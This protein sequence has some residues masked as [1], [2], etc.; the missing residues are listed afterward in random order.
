MIAGKYLIEELL[1]KLG[2][3]KRLN[4]IHDLPG[5]LTG[6][7]AI[8]TGGTR[9]LGLT[10][11]KALISKGC[12]VVIASSQ[13]KDKFTSLSDRV[14]NGI[15]ERDSRTGVKRGAVS[16]YNV[17]LSSMQSALDF[18]KAFKNE[19]TD[20]NYLIC[21]AGIMFAPRQLTPDGFESHLAINYLG[22]ALLILELLSLLKETAD[23]TKMNSRVVSVSSGTHHITRL[24]LEDLFSE[25][26]YSSSQ[27]YAQSKLA[28]IMFTYKLKRVMDSL[29]WSNVQCF[30][31]H[32]GIVLSELYE[33]VNLV[34]YLPFLVPLIKLVT[35]D[36]VQGAETT[37]Y[38]TLSEE[39]DGNCGDYLEDCKIVIPSARARDVPTQDRLWEITHGLLAPWLTIS[40]CDSK[41]MN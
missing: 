30:S 28:Q 27:A 39:L 17:D 18:V 37:L 3:K 22:H 19:N 35:R 14:Y 2:F 7:V 24:R 10:V 15:S 41:K 4:L 9:G 38:A 20:L 31:L 6:K 40:Y 12:N 8:V 5:D 23:R 25:T 36:M 29:K 16:I 32:P 21:N 11:V 26:N 33:H 13:A 1:Y 34:K